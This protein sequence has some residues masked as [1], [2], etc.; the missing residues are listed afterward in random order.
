M[1]SYTVGKAIETVDWDEVAE[2]E[3]YQGRQVKIYLI[4]VVY[5]SG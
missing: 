2:T 5:T 3:E 4:A 1:H